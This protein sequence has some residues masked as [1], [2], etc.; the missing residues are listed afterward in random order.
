MDVRKSRWTLIPIKAAVTFVE[1]FVPVWAGNEFNNWSAD[2]AEIALV[3]AGGAALSVLY[4]G[5]LQLK[6]WLDEV[7]AAGKAGL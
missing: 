6:S 7:N 1:V 4:N 2:S 3:S 5:L